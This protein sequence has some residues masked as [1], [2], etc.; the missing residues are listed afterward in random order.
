MLPT[1]VSHRRAVILIALLALALR[2]IFV[3]SPLVGIHGW[4][5]CDTAAVARNYFEE[6]MH[7]AFPRVDWRGDGPGYVEM[8][9]P[10]F[11]FAAA[12]IYQLAGSAHEWI[13]RLLAAIGGA[14]TAAYIV[15]L[16]ARRTDLSTG[17]CAG[18]F[19]ACLPLNIYYGAAFM[20]ESWLLLFSA[21]GV[22]HFALA[23][24]NPRGSRREA[25]HLV[26]SCLGITLAALLKLP[27]LY[28]GLPL[29]FLII[30]RDGW[31]GIVHPRHIAFAA[32]IFA[33]VTAWYWHA[34]NLGAQT[35]LSFG[36]FNSDKFRSWNVTFST[37]YWFDILVRRIAERHLTWAGALIAAVGILTPR[38][39][40]RERLFD[41]WMIALLIF[42]AVVSEGNRIHEY[43]QL[44]A[45]LPL[46]F[47]LAR[48]TVAGL[49]RRPLPWAALC[50][51]CLILSTARLTEYFER[52]TLDRSPEARVAAMVTRQ[53]NAPLNRII[54]VSNDLPGDP[55]VLYLAHAKGWA[56]PPFA[57]S[58]PNM[59]DLLSRGAHSVAWVG[60]H[61]ADSAAQLSA[62]YG[63]HLIDQD[64]QSGCLITDLSIAPATPP[65]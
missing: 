3:A 40:P 39:S 41:I 43:Y 4:R 34:H 8:E 60:P 25:V 59:Q 55:S 29:L 33:V 30:E 64:E 13:G 16:V 1:T 49:K 46:S 52:A 62:D 65:R 53:L 19:F 18:L 31:R 63:G 38:R 51:I 42:A 7:F 36:I 50:A 5:Q 48:A 14:A 6:G 10:L 37:D 28:L 35:G 2:L 9:F 47:Y 56:L 17:L 44:P 24:E 32:A 12:C 61:A 20:P 15:L 45:A 21:V 26:V 11:S 27:T 57:L 23:M 22:H 58:A 54:V